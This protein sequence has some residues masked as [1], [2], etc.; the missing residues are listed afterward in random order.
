[1]SS[2]PDDSKPVDSTPD[3][4]QRLNSA[5]EAA[6]MASLEPILAARF[7]AYL[8]LILRW[9]KRVNLTAIRDEEGI[10]ARHFVESIACARALPSGIGTLLD[11]G[12][13]AG[14]PGLPIA[15][16]RPEIA[17]TLAESQGKKAA[18]LQEAVRV[19]SL[20][21][22][23]L[24]ARA[25]SAPQLYDCVALRAVDHMPEAVKAAATLVREQ[26]WLVLMTTKPESAALQSAAK[27]PSSPSFIWHPSIPLPGSAERIIVLGQQVHP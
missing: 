20:S 3:A 16:C 7:A 1:M 12:S 11:F 27:S 17:V 23:V 2:S 26:G 21:T 22:R 15:L 19:L 6:G 8:S 4:A 14:L 24:P 25:E 5:L 9:N 10:I 13:G 18:F